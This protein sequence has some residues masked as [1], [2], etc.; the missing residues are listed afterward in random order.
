MKENENR[1]GH[2]TVGPDGNNNGI[3][4]LNDPRGYSIMMACV[5]DTGYSR[6]QGLNLV[7]WNGE[8]SQSHHGTTYKP[9][10]RKYDGRM[11]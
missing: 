10:R 6:A 11:A 1:C 4:R 2:C 8:E 5:C 7:R 9:Q 3:V